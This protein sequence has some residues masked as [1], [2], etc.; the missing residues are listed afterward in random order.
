LSKQSCLEEVALTAYLEGRMDSSIREPVETHLADCEACRGKLAFYMRI[1]DEDV[2]DE[3]EVAI[4][5][6]VSELR[7]KP[8]TMGRR[9]R[10]WPVGVAVAATLAL[11][12]GL[13]SQMDFSSRPSPQEILDRLALEERPF[14]ARLSDQTYLPLTQVRAPNAAPAARSMAARMQGVSDYMLGTFYL[15]IEQFDL[16]IERLNAEAQRANRAEVQNNLGVAYLE[17]DAG[18]PAEE[19]VNRREARAHFEQALEIEPAFAPSIFNLAILYYRENLPAELD[20]KV[21]EYRELDPN[22]GWADE[23]QRLQSN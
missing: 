8:V 7:K 23:L 22:S 17:R 4:D 1:L 12:V 2:R 18:G 14:E 11:A 13:G 21:R 9:R 10:W 5:H 20:V 16:A 15:H 6:L 3:E 19:A